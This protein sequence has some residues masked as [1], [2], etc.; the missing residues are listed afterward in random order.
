MSNH[1]FNWKKSGGMSVF[2]RRG[3]PLLAQVVPVVVGSVLHEAAASRAYMTV[4]RHS[5]LTP[6]L[7]VG[8]SGWSITRN[9]SSADGPSVAQQARA[10]RVEQRFEALKELEPAELHV[11][12]MSMFETTG[13]PGVKALCL[14][15]DKCQSAEDATLGVE[16]VKRFRAERVYN[17]LLQPFSE[18]VATKLVQAC[19][20]GGCIDQVLALLA[21]ANEEGIV[22]SEEMVAHLAAADSKLDEQQVDSI[23][24]AYNALQATQHVACADS[25]SAVM[26]TLLKGGE[27]ERS[28][29]FCDNVVGA[30]Q[31][32]LSTVWELLAQAAKKE[33]L[34][35]QAA[36]IQRKI[37]S[38]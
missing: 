23:V 10:T 8:S 19:V 9:F 11:T 35:D 30:G 12:L 21:R 16:L 15:L 34:A 26:L 37:A 1:K 32:P 6:F 4:G 29:L 13:P 14:F 31:K 25:T 7:A 24:D 27:I 5:T 20:R 28:L 17:L 22:L 36:V 33:G 2:S 38:L 18:E 3:V